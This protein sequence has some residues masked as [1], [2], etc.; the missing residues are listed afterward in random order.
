[1]HFGDD[2][3][4]LLKRVRELAQPKA[5]VLVK[6]SMFMKVGRVV[7]ALAGDPVAGGGH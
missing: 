2:L 4:A 7:S 6:G 1:M 3:D 5:C